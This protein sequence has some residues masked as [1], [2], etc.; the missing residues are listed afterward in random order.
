MGNVRDSLEA[1]Q[2]AYILSIDEAVVAGKKEVEGGEKKTAQAKKDLVN[3]GKA[4]EAAKA[5]LQA[6]EEKALQNVAALKEAE[7]VHAGL[8]QV[9]PLS[10]G[11]CRC[12]ARP[13][14]LQYKENAPLRSPFLCAAASEDALCC[15]A[16]ERGRGAAGRGGEAE[17]GG[18]H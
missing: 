8:P 12:T 11:P 13:V 3:A 5:K 1:A 4:V 2:E 9:R 14:A 6:Q 7:S 15:C 18:A 17:S 16:P 10:H